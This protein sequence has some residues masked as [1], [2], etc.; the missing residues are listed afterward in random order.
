ME[1]EGMRRRG[2]PRKTRWDDVYEDVKSS[3]L[4]Q[5]DDTQLWNNWRKRINGMEATI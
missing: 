2:C 3:G 5:E 4:S 1:V